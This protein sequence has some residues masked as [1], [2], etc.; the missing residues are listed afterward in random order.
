MRS[1]GRPFVAVPARLG[2]GGL[3]VERPE[4]DGQH[5]TVSDGLCARVPHH[6]PAR[7]G[8]VHLP[9]A[10]LGARP[11]GQPQHGPSVGALQRARQQQAIAGAFQHR[12]QRPTPA[13][14][15]VGIGR[16]NLGAGLVVGQARQV[17]DLVDN[18]QGAMAAHLGEVQLG[19]RRDT[20]V[21]SDVAGEAAGG[22]GLVV[23]GADAETVPEG[24]PPARI[25][26]GLLGLKT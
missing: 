10:R 23:G 2:P 4:G 17:M 19:G 9:G 26:E 20:L 14:G 15:L 24:F 25:G 22:V 3:A 5:R 1:N 6:G 8:E 11:V 21:G 7:G 12:Q 16:I 13:R 18:Q